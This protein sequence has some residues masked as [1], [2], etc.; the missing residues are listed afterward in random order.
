MKAEG[1]IPSLDGWRGISILLVIIGHEIVD[2]SH[3]GI[4]DRNYFL[5]F[6]TWHLYGVK[7]FFVISGFIITHLLC[8]EERSNGSVS[9]RKFYLRR[10]FR[11][12]PVVYTYLI[13]LFAV[14]YFYHNE[15]IHSIVWFLSFFF[16]A[17]FES[18]GT[19]WSTSHLWSLSVE[20]QFYFLWPMLFLCKRIWR[21][22][23]P[24]GFI[25]I[26]PI[27]RMIEYKHPGSIGEF[28]FF[29][30]ADAIF[31]GCLYALYREKIFEKRYKVV[32]LIERSLSP[33][34]FLYKIL[35]I[36]AFDPSSSFI[37]KNI[38][39]SYWNYECPF[40]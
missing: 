4:N 5:H 31:I 11:I 7:I 9:L 26:A 25:L 1:R 15:I 37:T 19:A 33:I 13:I 17:N 29:I 20:E 30:H 2:G 36:S 10:F 38:N 16:S 27:L 28:S 32:I 23:I 39:T 18:L 22:I 8:K 14:S 35:T 3:F 12:I 21:L 6:F 24:I 40:Y 34:S